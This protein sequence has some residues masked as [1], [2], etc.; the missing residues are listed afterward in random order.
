MKDLLEK[1]SISAQVAD[2]LVKA[3]V[4]RAFELGLNISVSVLD[5]AGNELMFYRMDRAPLISIES[6]R[7]KAKLALGFGIPTGESWYNFIKDDEILKQGAG[8]LPGFILL[9]GGSPIY[10]GPSLVGSIGVSGGHYKQD[11][12]CVTAALQ[13]LEI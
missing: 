4:K 2:T 9:G 5:D 8:D 7:K 11:E 13:I 12:Q 10:A 1:K 3:A 6:S